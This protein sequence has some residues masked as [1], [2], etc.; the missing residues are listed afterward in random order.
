MRA[1]MDR[2]AGDDSGTLEEL[3]LAALYGTEDPYPQAALASEYLRRGETRAA[4]ETVD[5]A[6]A[7]APDHVPSLIVKARLEM[8]R[9]NSDRAIALLKTAGAEAPG[10]LDV[11]TLLV[12]AHLSRG[13]TRAAATVAEKLGGALDPEGIASQRRRV[14]AL[15]DR[16]AEAL[17][18]QGAN[19][20]AA[21][22]LQRAVDLEPE[23]P[24]RLVALAQFLESRGRASDA[25]GAYA[26]A[27]GVSNDEPRFALDAAR[28]Y[29]KEGHRAEAAAYIAV[30]ADSTRGRVPLVR[31]GDM[32]VDAGAQNEA[33]SA[34]RA[35]AE[36][37]PGWS[38]PLTKAAELCERAG[39]FEEAA[40]YYRRVPETDESYAL[41]Q[42]SA[43]VCDLR[44]W[45]T[46]G[47]H[48]EA[49]A[50][51]EKLGSGS[52]PSP[53][54]LDF[55]ARNLLQAKGDLVL[56]E[57]RARQAVALAPGRGD[58]LVTLGEVLL[59]RQSSEAFDVLEKAAA[60]LPDRPN[61]QAD[62]AEAAVLARHAD[63]AR[64]ALAHVEA[65][66]SRELDEAVRARLATLRARVAAVDAPAAAPAMLRATGER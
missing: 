18:A 55:L 63:A 21:Q 9:G 15:L 4:D 27:L 57:S 61:V 36:L 10:N 6:L 34:Y 49:V 52:A 35:G 14:A 66:L 38:E 16:V 1:V 60:A 43:Q 24:E 42:A 20:R 45:A 44:A 23:N 41:A 46:E 12:D 19:D 39:H 3:R 25:A 17:A 50:L 2:C 30:L 53:D 26:R 64:A 29:L 22:L 32:L 37:A 58:L 51:A 65:L 28:L 8:D 40:S 62:L 33:L 7:G 47:R 54:A 5:A 56:A 11:P 31:L 48:E 13:E 59:A